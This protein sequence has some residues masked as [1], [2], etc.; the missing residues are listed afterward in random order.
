MDLDRFNAASL[1]GRNSGNSLNHTQG[2]EGETIADECYGNQ[3][4][5]RVLCLSSSY[6]FFE[7]HLMYAQH[8]TTSV[9]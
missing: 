9:C 2:I 6:L 8:S 7:I 4:L 3:D 5:V 1:H